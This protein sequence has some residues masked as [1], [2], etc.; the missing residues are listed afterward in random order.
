MIGISIE[1]EFTTLCKSA[2]SIPF[3]N[4]SDVLL[5]ALLI[6]DADTG[7]SAISVRYV[8]DRFTDAYIS[9]IG[10][11]F[12]MKRVTVGDTGVQLQIW[13][14]AGQER[15]H[16]IAAS[17][18]RVSN[19][20]AILY[21]VCNRDTFDHVSFWMSQIDKYAEAGV[22]RMLVG[23]KCD[24][25]ARVVSTEEGKALADQYNIDFIEVSAKDDVNIDVMFDRLAKQMFDAAGSSAPH[26]PQNLFNEDEGKNKCC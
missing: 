12:R 13:E 22:V 1:A 18:Y 16:S 17:Y 19:G 9:T 20:I 7:K 15:F 21:D 4:P 3:S 6:G 8:E 5:K 14:T 11:E 2:K 10:C 24:S 23:N 26:V 25:S